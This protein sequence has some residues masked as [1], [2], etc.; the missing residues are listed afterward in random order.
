MKITFDN[1]DDFMDFVP[2]LIQL[3]I[4]NDDYLSD[5]A[6]EYFDDI[7]KKV[8][9]VTRQYFTANPKLRLK[10]NRLLK[11]FDNNENVI[12]AIKAD[13]VTQTKEGKYLTESWEPMEETVK[14]Y[15]WRR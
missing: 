15:L 11:G 3:A 14:K 5:D 9:A 12:L 4:K 8:K 6:S 13:K 10:L 1:L 2:V 7:S